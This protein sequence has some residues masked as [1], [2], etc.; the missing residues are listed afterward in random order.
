MLIFQLYVY[1]LPI[2]PNVGD[3]ILAIIRIMLP[4]VIYSR[5]KKFFD[6]EKD[7]DLIREYNKKQILPL[8]TASIMIIVMVYFTSGYF[9]YTTIAIASS[10]MESEISKGDVVIVEK[11]DGKYEKLKKGQVIAYEY[12][13]TTI[14]HRLIEIIKA[15]DE[16]YFYTKGDANKDVDKYVLYQENIKGIVKTKI[17]YIGLP[18][19]WLSEI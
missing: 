12:N 16:Y 8:V 19:V 15:E 11:I 9:K 14:V 2:I 13:G 6:K 1:I 18:T 3:Y 17:P 7:E 10:S 4:L 5:I